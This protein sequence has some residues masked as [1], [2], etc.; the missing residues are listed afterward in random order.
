MMLSAKYKEDTSLPS[1]DMANSIF[2][3][4]DFLNR[5]ENREVNYISQDWGLLNFLFCNIFLE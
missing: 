2:E 3:K 5:S 4:F 1:K